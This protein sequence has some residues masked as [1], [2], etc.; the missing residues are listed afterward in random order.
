MMQC[1]IACVLERLLSYAT[2][3]RAIDP[4]VQL[5]ALQDMVL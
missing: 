1:L 3:T 2:K 5:A 4:A